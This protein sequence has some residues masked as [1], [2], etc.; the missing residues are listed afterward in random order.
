MLLCPRQD[1]PFFSC[2]A[3]RYRY[4][5]VVSGMDELLLLLLCETDFFRPFPHQ[6]LSH[7]LS[8]AVEM[9]RLLFF[10]V[11]EIAGRGSYL[12]LPTA[13]SG[14]KK[15]ST[16]LYLLPGRKVIPKRKERAGGIGEKVEMMR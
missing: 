6:Y 8:S 9:Y 13:S 16:A 4:P 15:R 12:P 11:P 1:T 14:E 5:S 7:P 10:P 2:T 3:T